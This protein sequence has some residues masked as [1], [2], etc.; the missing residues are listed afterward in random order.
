M[1]YIIIKHFYIPDTQAFCTIIL[2]H[3]SLN[4]FP[5]FR[6]VKMY[7]DN[8]IILTL[9]LTLDILLHSFR[10]SVE[11]MRSRQFFLR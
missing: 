5:S 3:A 7:F 6:T 10:L 9:F 11:K 4:V 2:F 1:R 8:K